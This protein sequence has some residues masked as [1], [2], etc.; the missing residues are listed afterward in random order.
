MIDL[1]GIDLNEEQT[2]KVTA[3][4]DSE[5]SGLKNKVDE[6]LGEKKNVQQGLTEKEQA[7]EDARKAAVSAEEQR[8]VEAGQYKEALALREKEVA[9]AMA[10]ATN[11]AEEAKNALLSRD[12]G[13][14]L[15]KLKS[16]VRDDLRGVSEAMLSNMIEIGYNEDKSVSTSFL[17][18]GEKI[19]DSVEGF[20]SWAENN[21]TLKHIMK[22]VDSSGAGV[23]QSKSGAQLTNKPYSEMTLQEQVAFNKQN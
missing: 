20:K 23:T 3:L 21:E 22:G 13:D 16:L 12:K 1:S 14:V 17:H 19:A 7:L 9:E 4:I 11:S 18:N 2:A 6:L 10:Q 8:L 15:N 5:V